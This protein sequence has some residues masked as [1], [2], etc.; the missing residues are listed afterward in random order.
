MSWWVYVVRCT[1]G[2]LY[3]GVATRLAARLRQHNTDDRRGAR[4]TRG[5]RPVALHAARRCPDRAAATRLERRVK[6]LPRARKIA[7]PQ[8][9]DWLDAADALC[10][11][12]A[13][14]QTDAPAASTELGDAPR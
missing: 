14:E 2:T 5:R 10:I 9:A 11:A 8:T 6:R 4:Y 7:L 12:M 13:E 3:T 1:D